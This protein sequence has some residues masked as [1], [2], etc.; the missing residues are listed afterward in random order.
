VTAPRIDT[1]P[2]IVGSFLSD[3]AHVPGGHA[4]GVAFPR[5]IADVAALVASADHV[6]P[7]GAQSSLTGGA[8]PRGDIVLSTRALDWIDLDAGARGVP[9]DPAQATVRVGA[10][11]PLAELQRALAPRGLYYPPVPTYDGA[12]VGGTLSTNAAGAATFKYGSARRWVQAMTIV[13][14]D[15]RILTLERGQM[16]AAELAPVPTYTMPDVPKLSAGYYARPGMDAV[17]LF[18]GSEGTLGVIAEATLRVIALPR[19]CAALVTCDSDAQAVMV[20]AAL[21]DH[22][23]RAWRGDGPLDVAAVEYM[24]ARALAMVPDDAFDRAVVPRPAAGQVMLLVQIEVPREEEDA[25][26]AFAHVLGACGVENDPVLALPGDDRGA[27]RMFELR[28]A[29]PSSVNRYIAGVKER[30]DPRV[31]KTAGDMIVPFARLEESIALYRRVF[32]EHG[33][34]YA[35]WGHVSDG[36]LHPNVIPQSMRDVDDGHEAILEMARAV[37]AMGGAPLAE[38]GVGRSAL[39]QLLLR[40]LYGE[41]GIEEMRAVKRALDPGWKLSSGVLFPAG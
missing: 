13:L 39:K 17:D 6:L 15:G 16:R 37:V 11:V 25:L 22:G 32:E 5:T 33:L 28:E 3:A 24:D 19:R 23:A 21:R 18:V 1:H 4:L 26:I 38:H 31:H 41:R 40:E 36:N 34:G 30:V 9:G 27:A 7:V 14:A 29:V 35:I 8:T 2:D 20:T 10:G 12:F